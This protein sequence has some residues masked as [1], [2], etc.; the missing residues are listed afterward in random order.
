MRVVPL[1]DHPGAMRRDAQRRRAA[2]DREARRAHE[3]VLAVHRER[4][5]QAGAARDEAWAAR[6]W[7]AWLRGVL[8]VRRARRQAPAV[9]L[10]A[11]QPTA[12]EER[13]AA[14]SA[15]ELRVAERT[16]PGA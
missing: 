10:P 12:E 14:G 4:V 1:S 11:S 3:N 2:A 5:A 8:A 13:W 9:R 15:G 16:W 7:T 6:R